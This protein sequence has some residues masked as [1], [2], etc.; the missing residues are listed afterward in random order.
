M[1][2]T[3]LVCP[4]RRC[5]RERSG[6]VTSAVVVSETCSPHAAADLFFLFGKVCDLSCHYAY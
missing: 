5:N 1:D 2:G 6:I 3:F 4:E